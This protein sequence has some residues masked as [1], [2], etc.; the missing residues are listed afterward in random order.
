MIIKKYRVNPGMPNPTKIPTSIKT[1]FVGAG[2]IS[3]LLHAFVVIDPD[4]P[5]E[6]HDLMAVGDETHLD[7]SCQHVYVGTGILN[8]TT[9]HHVFRKLAPS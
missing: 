2:Y 9:V 7:P 5:L 4:D 8:G 3:G 6:T 1:R